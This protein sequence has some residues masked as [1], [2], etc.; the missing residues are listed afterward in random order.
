MAQNRA[1]STPFIESEKYTSFILRNLHDGL[2]PGSFYRNVT[3]FGS[4]TTLHIKSVGTVT[5]QDG[6]ED[7]PFD[8]TAIEAGEVTLTINNYIL[9]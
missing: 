7:V 1:N 6:A 2:L 4:G 9:H 5:I 8:Y 3:D